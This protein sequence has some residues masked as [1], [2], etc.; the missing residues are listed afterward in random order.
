MSREFGVSLDANR[1]RVLDPALTAWAGAIVCMDARDERLL[2]SVF[3]DTK[4]KVF[5]LG[6]FNG[7]ARGIFIAD[8]WNRPVEEF[9]RC[10]AEVAAGVDGLIEAVKG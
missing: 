3:P 10:F 7:T 8:P 9:R 6:A 5:Y 4:E 2:R 1:S